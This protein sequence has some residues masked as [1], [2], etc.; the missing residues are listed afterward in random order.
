MGIINKTKNPLKPKPRK[1][2]I[3]LKT[4]PINQPQLELI[5]LH[6]PKEMNSPALDLTHLLLRPPGQRCSSPQGSRHKLST[7]QLKSRKYVNSKFN[8]SSEPRCASSSKCRVEC[9][10]ET[11]AHSLTAEMN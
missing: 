9:V 1:C 8:R 7:W 6:S 2:Q 10:S 5:H 4:I 11:I 3:L